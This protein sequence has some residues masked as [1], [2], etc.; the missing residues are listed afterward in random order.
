METSRMK[1]GRRGED[2]ACKF[3]IDRGHTV[4]DRNWRS[5]HLEI[6][7]VTVDPAGLH[8][9]EVKSR[10]AP[11]PATPEENVGYLKQRRIVAAAKRYLHS[12]EKMSHFGQMEVFFDVFSVIFEG[13]KVEVNYFPQAYIPVNI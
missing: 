8:F 6:D 3:L 7:I 2:I 10:V 13:E 12:G 5:G 4:V 9:V 1:L 11:A